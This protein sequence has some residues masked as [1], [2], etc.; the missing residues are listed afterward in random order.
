MV[1]QWLEMSPNCIQVLGL[2]L[3]ADSGIYMWSFWGIFV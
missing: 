3:L 2:K 1:V